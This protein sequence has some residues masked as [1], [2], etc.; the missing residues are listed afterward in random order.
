MRSKFD[1]NPYLGGSNPALCTRIFIRQIPRIA[2]LIE[3]RTV[4]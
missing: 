1:S 2:Q 4:V 3:R